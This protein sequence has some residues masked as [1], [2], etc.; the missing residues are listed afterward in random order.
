MHFLKIVFLILQ[1]DNPVLFYLY[2]NRNIHRKH[3]I[4]EILNLF[5]YIKQII[6]GSRLL[7]PTVFLSKSLW[8]DTLTF[9]CF[10]NH[11]KDVKVYWNK[12]II[13]ETKK[14]RW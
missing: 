14:E 7:E 4:K 5:C 8:I 11:L 2:R 3:A 12:N 13:H 9:V 1:T 10:G 6:V